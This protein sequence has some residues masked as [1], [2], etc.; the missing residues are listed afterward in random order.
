M[1]NNKEIQVEQVE[2]ILKSY[3]NM[4]TLIKIDE[5]NKISMEIY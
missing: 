4:Y 2:E 5:V 3:D 1:E